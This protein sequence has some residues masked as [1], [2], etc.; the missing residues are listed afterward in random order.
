MQ[1]QIE[2]ELNGGR[3]GNGA[4]SFL[5]EKFRPKGGP[6]GGDGGDGGPVI[7]RAMSHLRSLDHLD[8]VK[9]IVG[10]AG[11]PGRSKNRTGGKG[12]ASYV[13]VPVGTVVWTCEED[14]ERTLLTELTSDRAEVVVAYSGTGGLGNARFATS[15]N[16]EPLLAVGGEPGEQ[17]LVELEVKLF[18]D[19]GLVGAP[20]AGKST[21]LSVVSRAK[22]KVADYPFTTL[23][24]VLGV[25]TLGERTIVALD[26]PGLIEGAHRGRGLGLEFLRHCERAIVLIQLVDGMAEDL[27][28][29]YAAIADELLRYGAGLETKARVVAVTKMDI[30]EAK[31]RFV[32]QR[33]AL[34]TTAGLEPM[35]IASVTGE[36]IPGLLK[37]LEGL[38][39]PA[40][41]NVDGYMPPQVPRLRR[42]DPRPRVVRD[43]DAYAVSCPPAERILEAVSLSSWR[44]RLQFHRE[45]ERLGVIEALE[46]AG[47]GQGD[48]VRIADFEFVWE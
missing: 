34:A 13:D 37:R 24:P 18:A 14:A 19:V 21:L 46:R 25:V 32:E 23:A 7:A 12:K 17:R 45:L 36:G 38:I 1:D 43:E 4:V 40:E 27:A 20:N 39:P 22:P 3:G 9:G 2:I 33:M 30:P 48:T 10:A 28:A 29:D 44:A 5:R 11:S 8:G 26:I 16:Q 41:D 15:T 6:D 47:A 35:G 42:P 31:A